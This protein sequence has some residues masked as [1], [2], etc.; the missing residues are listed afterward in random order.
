MTP[1][2]NRQDNDKL[3]TISFRK[4][5]EKGIKD[6][7]TESIIS[8]TTAP[9]SASTVFLETP[10]L[11]LRPLAAEDWRD[12]YVTLTDAEIADLTGWQ[13]VRSEQE[14]QKYIAES[15]E[16]DD[17]LAVVLRETMKT[18]GT[19]SVQ[20]RPW[21]EYPVDRSLHGR[22]FGFDLCRSLWGNGLMPEAVA[23]MCGYCFR[24]LKF[25]FITCG[26]FQRNVRSGHT[27]EKCGFMFLYQA[28]RRL[29]TGKT[30]NILTYI[31]YSPINLKGEI[32]HV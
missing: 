11:L 26:H 7:N 25:D 22:E 5:C 6:L 1:D 17:T 24:D 10:R 9:F 23:A 32:Q 4:C 29:P 15:S 31:R 13:P 14:A 8:D 28:D 16:K 19:F 21:E 27:I 3:L 2:I 12:L 18:V 30:E 20:E